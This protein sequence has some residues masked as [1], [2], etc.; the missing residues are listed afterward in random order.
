M[1]AE[2]G[3]RENELSAREIRPCTVCG[4]RFSATAE[5][6]L[7][8]ICLLQ[9]SLAGGIEAPEAAV[10]DTVTRVQRIAWSITSW[11]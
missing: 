11:S 3:E 8:P 4:A 7:C 10:G 2:P 5:D 6:G 9:G 1:N